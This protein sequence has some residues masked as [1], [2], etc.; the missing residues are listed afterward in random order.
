MKMNFEE[1]FRGWML[2]IIFLVSYNL[3]YGVYFFFMGMCLFRSGVDESLI[4]LN[5]GKYPF[6]F[7]RRRNIYYLKYVIEVSI[8]YY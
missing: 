5:K 6:K 7:W 4:K 3:L 1:I 2:P 8:F